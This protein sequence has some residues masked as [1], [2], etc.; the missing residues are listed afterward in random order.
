VLACTWWLPDAREA[1]VHPRHDHERIGSV[2]REPAVRWFFASLLFHI[3]AHFAIYGFFSL[4]LDARGYSKAMIGTL[5]AVSVLVEIVW[6]FGQGR[7][8]SRGSMAGWL[9]VCGAATVVRMLIM[10]TAVDWLAAL[11]VAQALHALSFAAHHTACIAFVT[12]RFPG[13]LRA[14]GQ[15]LFTVVGYGCGGVTGVLLGGQIVARIGYVPV[16]V[17]ATVLGLLATWSG[18]QLMRASAQEAR[19]HT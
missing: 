2:L 13:R 8:I 11:F 12:R 4:Y 7:W 10:A 3:T 5:W 18:W 17:S 15:A 9:V 1:P 16:F 19:A 6:F 14:R